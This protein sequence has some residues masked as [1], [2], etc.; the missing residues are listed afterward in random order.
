MI[1]LLHKYILILLLISDQPS[2]IRRESQ[3]V[4]AEN[5][6][7]ASKACNE[8]PAPTVT[9]GKGSRQIKGSDL[10]NQQFKALIIKRFQHA[11]R[12]HKDFFAQIV[13]PASFVL[14]ALV[15]TLI[16]PPFG[17][18]PSLTLHPW[19]YGQQFIFFSNEHPGSEQVV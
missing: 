9:N 19:I 16:V 10:M 5:V 4:G 3:R 12:S 14:L 15:F 11:T 8:Q 18:Y 2:D 13:L 17:E 7:P 1:T 6:P